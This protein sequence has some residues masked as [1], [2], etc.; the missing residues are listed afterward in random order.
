MNT[1]HIDT[2][3]ELCHYCGNPACLICDDC[4]ESWCHCDCEND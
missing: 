3:N 4:E 1:N 2:E